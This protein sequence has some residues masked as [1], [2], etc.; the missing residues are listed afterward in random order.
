MAAE[1]LRRGEVGKRTGEDQ[2]K[3][4]GNAR[5]RQRHR[6]RAKH[7]QARG[8]ERIGRVLQIGVDAR[9]NGGERHE[10]HRKEGERLGNEGAPEPVEVEVLDAQKRED[11]AVG[12]EQQRER[13]AACKG[14]GDERQDGGCADKDL[15]PAGH[16]QPRHRIGEDKAQDGARNAH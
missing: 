10:R 2:Q 9:E 4:V 13:N 8:A 7:R 3:G 16:V 5:H 11:H 15:E 12:P 6:H 14:R 1:H